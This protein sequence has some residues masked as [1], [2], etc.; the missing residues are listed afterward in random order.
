MIN[1]FKYYEYNKLRTKPEGVNDLLETVMYEYQH[2]AVME[3]MQKGYLTSSMSENHE[4]CIQ[5]FK[6]FK[7]S[8]EFEV[9]NEGGCDCVG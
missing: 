9:R 5:E 6:D 3:D 1:F 4:N 7:V 8:I 2:C